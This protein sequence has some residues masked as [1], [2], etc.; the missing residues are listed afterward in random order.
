MSGDQ[1]YLNA[2]GE[3]LRRRQRVQPAGLHEAERAQAGDDV[4]AGRTMPGVRQRLDD[5]G[6]WEQ[7]VAGNKDRSVGR[8]GI[9]A[10]QHGTE[11]PEL[12]GRPE[13][14]NATHIPHIAPDTEREEAVATAREGAEMLA[15]R[16]TNVPRH[17]LEVGQERMAH[18][19]TPIAADRIAL[20]V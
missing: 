11:E 1:T 2:P 8:P 5:G 10:G 12:T 14:K 7:S 6:R 18:A 15:A 20:S 16:Y 4:Q 17:A 9:F 13:S 3:V 19:D